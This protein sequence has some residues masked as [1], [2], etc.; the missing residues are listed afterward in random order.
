MFNSPLEVAKFEGAAMQTVSGE[1]K[2]AVMPGTKN[3]GK[4]KAF[5]GFRPGAT[6]CPIKDPVV[7]EVVYVLR[8]WGRTLKRHNV[9]SDEYF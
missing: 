4:P 2:K 6:V 9:V 1:I 7:K 8:E 3:G 5:V